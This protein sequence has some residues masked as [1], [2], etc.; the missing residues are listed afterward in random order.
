MNELGEN[1]NK[2]WMKYE[3]FVNKVTQIMNNLWTKWHKLWI[4][5]EQS[6]TNYEQFVNEATDLQLVHK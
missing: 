1:M 4:I 3:Q 5:Y 6:N 2:L